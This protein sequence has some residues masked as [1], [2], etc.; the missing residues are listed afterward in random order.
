MARISNVL[1]TIINIV[2][3]LFS[4]VIIGSGAYLKFQSKSECA[5]FFHWPLIIFGVGLFVFSLFGIFGACCSITF[6]L[7]IYLFVLFL[8]IFAMFSV[9]V[10]VFVVTNKG[11]GQAISGRG[12]KEYRLGDYSN[13]IQKNVRD[14]KN[15]QTIESC[16]SVGQVCGQF[17]AGSILSANDFYKQ[18]LSPIQSGCCKPPTYCGYSYVNSTFWVEPKT[19][20]KSADP[21]CKAWSNDQAKLCYDC[22]SCKAGVLATIKRKWKEIAIINVVIIVVL[23]IFYTVG[24]CAIRNNRNDKYKRQFYGGYYR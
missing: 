11:A 12:Y 16:F 2:I 22:N 7:W 5:E 1:I 20:L 21:D 14:Y 9:T 18:A 6:F 19:G 17:N 23:L 24:C 4:L 10:F 8:L 13:W 3:L 15:W